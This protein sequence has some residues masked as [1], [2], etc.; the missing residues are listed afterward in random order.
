MASQHDKEFFALY[1]QFKDNWD[2]D[3][4][5][6]WWP[7]AE[8]DTPTVGATSGWVRWNHLPGEGV[9]NDFGS[10]TAIGLEYT[11]IVIIQVFTPVLT[12]QT[13]NNQLC[14]TVDEVYFDFRSTD[15]GFH[16]R[17][18]AAYRNNVGADGAWYQQNV[19]VP[20]VRES[21]RSA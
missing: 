7:N 12:G 19:V 18:R 3:T 20:Y 13:A 11:G 15:G 2:A 6:V 5:P 17:T 1:D 4:Y 21:I 16:I 14:D 10:P 8:F 9:R